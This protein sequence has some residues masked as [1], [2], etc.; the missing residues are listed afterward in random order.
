MHQSRGKGCCDHSYVYSS[1]MYAWK[2]HLWVHIDKC[3]LTE[4]YSVAQSCP[5]LCNPIDCSTPGLPVPHP[6][7]KFARD[8]I[9]CIGGVIQP[10]HLFPPP[11]PLPSVFPSIRV[12]SSE[13]TLHLSWPE[14]W[15]F[16]F[17]I[18]LTKEYLGLISFRMTGLMISLQSRKLSVVFS[19]S[20]VGKY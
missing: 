16:S 9:H 19:S 4:C 12:F 8:H 7:P 6:L 13:S 5:A 10:S 1:T 18:S 20:T 17:S 2:I 14:Y 15:S 11:S 3:T